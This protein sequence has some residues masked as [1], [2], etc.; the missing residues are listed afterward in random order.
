MQI[1]L[2]MFVPLAIVLFAV[3]CHARLGKMRFARR[4]TGLAIAFRLQKLLSLIQKHRGISY[5][6]LKGDDLAATRLPPLQTEIGATIN[7]LAS[8]ISFPSEQQ[9]WNEI[10]KHWLRLKP[11]NLELDARNNFDQHCRLVASL[12][13][14]TEDIFESCY[15]SELTDA[16]RERAWYKVLLT[17]EW[18]GQVRALGSG[19]LVTRS[20][21]GADKG[22]LQSLSRQ[23]HKAGIELHALGVDNTMMLDLLQV[24][25]LQISLEHFESHTAESFFAMATEAMLPMMREYERYME[26]LAASMGKIAFQ[27]VA[28][29]R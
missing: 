26:E 9:H 16:T 7:S 10:E 19:A 4:S 11:R 22:R 20:L 3:G 21:W 14:L 6:V 12:L 5:R 13:T 28:P 24:V 8:M 29:R 23:L 1:W 18:I 2:S 15:L 27:Q 25:D 17:A